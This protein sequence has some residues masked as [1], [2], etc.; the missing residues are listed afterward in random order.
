MTKRKPKEEHKK[1]GQPT[2]YKESYNKEAYRLALLGCTDAEIAVFFEVT[3]TTINNWKLSHPKFF[4]SIKDGKVKADAKVAESMFKKA[5]GYTKKVM[6]PFVVKG[7]I[8]DHEVEEHFEP[9]T[10]A[11]QVW[12]NNRRP[13]DWKQKQTVVL[14][15]QIEDV[16]FKPPE[17]IEKEEN[18]DKQT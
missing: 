15:N 4:E 2:S 11:A 17:E 8:E 9:D 5:T 10:R 18:E 13:K 3:E 16:D 14:D 1:S 6:K 7:E 12:L